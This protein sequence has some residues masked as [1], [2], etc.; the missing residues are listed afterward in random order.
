VESLGIVK[1]KVGADPL[2]RIP[3][4]VVVVDI[5]VLILQRA[6]ESLDED[7]V[8]GS[9]SAV[10]A[11]GNGFVEKQLGKVIARKL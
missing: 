7:I 9:P 6:P 8:E 3:Y 5:D 2:P 4:G 10:H 11:D 1:N